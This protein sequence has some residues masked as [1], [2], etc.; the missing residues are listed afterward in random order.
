MTMGMNSVE[1]FEVNDYEHYE[2]RVDK[3]YFSWEEVFINRMGQPNSTEEEMLQIM[4]N[5][6]FKELYKLSS[7]HEKDIQSMSVQYNWSDIYK[8]LYYLGHPPYLHNGDSLIG[9]FYG[10]IEATKMIL[11][12]A[13]ISE[14]ED[15]FNECLLGG[16][17]IFNEIFLNECLNNLPSY[18]VIDLIKDMDVNGSEFENFCGLVNFDKLKANELTFKL[19]SS[20]DFVLS[21]E[22]Q[23][24][25]SIDY[26]HHSLKGRRSFVLKAV[27]INGE[28]LREVAEEFQNDREVVMTA[29]KKNGEALCWAS[30]ELKNDEEIVRQAMKSNPVSLF[31]ASPRFQVDK[32]MLNMAR[33]SFNKIEHPNE[34]IL[35]MLNLLER[36]DRSDELQKAMSKST[37]EVTRNKRKI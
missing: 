21:R 26:C 32:E 14:Y 3:G 30:D 4:R 23:V 12:R 33:D 35:I 13:D 9:S 15:L 18:K 27:E 17:K 29:I 25:N 2:K 7:E 6:E 19:L 24:P 31:Y 1:Y 28:F 10:D 16:D 37:E 34:K 36:Y 8:E 11:E 22:K 20:E 5:C